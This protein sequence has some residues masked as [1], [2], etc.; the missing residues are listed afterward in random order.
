MDSS[1][2]PLMFKGPPATTET[3]GG[4]EVDLAEVDLPVDPGDGVD[5]PATTETGGGAAE[6]ATTGQRSCRT[7]VQLHW[8]YKNLP[9]SVNV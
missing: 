6:Y 4:A 7:H 1:Q 2:L 9:P 5:P 3:A 8:T